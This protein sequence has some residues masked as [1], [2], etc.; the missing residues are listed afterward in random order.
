M[1]YIKMLSTLN[2]LYKDAVH[3]NGLHKDV[4]HIK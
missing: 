4:V 2:G 1:A 3:I